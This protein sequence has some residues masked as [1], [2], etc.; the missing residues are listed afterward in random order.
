M[1]KYYYID[2]VSKLQCGP[3]N[4]NELLRKNIRPETMVWCPGMQ[5]WTEAGALPELAF[6][7][8]SGISTPQVTEETPN[9]A[10]TVASRLDQKTTAANG[11]LHPLPKTWLIEAV[12]FTFIC[13]S[14]VSL[15][16]I[17][18]AIRVETHYSERNYEK[19]ERASNR[20][21]NWG[22]GGILFWPVIY[23]IYSLAMFGTLVSW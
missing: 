21:K 19:A 3:F 23:V 12:I 2:D 13:C 18:F 15:I 5:G 22:L 11:T 4:T 7:F 6:L 8:D 20:A 10:V 9:P 16:G 17:F 1:T 14:P